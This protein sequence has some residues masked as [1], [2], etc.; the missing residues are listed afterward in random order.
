MSLNIH[1][2]IKT[3]KEKNTLLPP[4]KA[5]VQLSC[6]QTHTCRYIPS[7]S[8]YESLPV[9]AVLLMVKLENVFG[10]DKLTAFKI[11]PFKS[12]KLNSSARMSHITPFL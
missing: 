7:Y 11:M 3:G 12:V 4:H 5:K 2:N 9:N 8:W 10:E 6:E 1:I